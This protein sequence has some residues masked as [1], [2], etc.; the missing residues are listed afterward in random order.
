MNHCT[1]QGNLTRDIELTYLP[2]GRAKCEI[3]L[4]VNHVYYTKDQEKKEEVSFPLIRFFGRRAENAASNFRKGSPILIE[5][6]YV[7]EQWEDKTTGEKR[8]RSRFDGINWHFCGPKPAHV[9]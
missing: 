4:A 9:G 7:Q 8:H 6:R 1:F 2:D 5:C 3:P